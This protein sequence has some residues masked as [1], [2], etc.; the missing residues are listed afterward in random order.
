[1]EETVTEVDMRALAL[2]VTLGF[3]A[4]AAG[5]CATNNDRLGCAAGGA[6][7]GGVAGGVIGNNTG[8]GDARRGAEVGAAAGAITGAV[9]GC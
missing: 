5:G 7:V 2:A 9:T 6:V 1:V 8:D 3:A 4:V